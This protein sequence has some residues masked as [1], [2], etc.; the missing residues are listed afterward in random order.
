MS[1]HSDTISGL[2]DNGSSVAESSGCPLWLRPVR[3]LLGLRPLERILLVISISLIFWLKAF[4]SVWG[5]EEL[6]WILKPVTV[7]V[8]AFSGLSFYFDPARGYVCPE[9]AIVIGPGCAG[10]NYLVTASLMGLFYIIH[11][12]RL[13]NR[14]LAL[15]AILPMAYVLTVLVNSLRIDG[16]LILMEL[17][18]S[19]EY[20]VPHRLHEAQGIAVF[21]L[22]LVLYFQLLRFFFREKETVNGR[23]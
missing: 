9:A 15:M 7:L 20:T 17:A 5:P 13:R 23:L 19:L 6:A 8:Q 16:A 18:R 3:L 12:P 21:F 2:N 22:F 4:Y 1:V 11:K 14:P 10:I